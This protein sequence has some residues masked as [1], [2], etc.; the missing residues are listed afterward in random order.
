M[1]A[2]VGTGG[3][4]GYAGGFAVTTDFCPPFQEPV[5][6]ILLSA[7]AVLAAGLLPQ[8][9]LADDYTLHTFERIELTDTYF[10]EGAGVGDIN[11]DGH[12]DVV[13]GP[14]WFAGPDFKN[15]HEIYPAEP[16]NRKG[17]AN[18]FFSW[19][20]DF[21]GDGH[22]DVLA[23]GF[24]GTP[25]Y[26]YE[27]PGPDA[28][29]QLWE[30]HQV[31]DWVSNESPQLVNLVG[32]ET[33]ELVCTT[34]GKFGYVTVNKEEPFGT[35]EFTVIS[36]Q[37]VTERFGHGLG[38]GDVN[39]DGLMDILTKDGWFEQPQ[40]SGRRQPADSPEWTFH[41]VPFA[42]RGGA[43][44]FAYDVDGD[45]DND[46]ITSLAAHEFGLA[47]WEQLDDGEWK[48]HLI[49]GSKR[50]ENKYGVLF[51][52]LHAVALVDMDGDG[53]KDIVTGKT[54]W[55]HHEQSPMWDAGAVVYWFKLVRGEDGVD[56][57][58]FQI[59]GDT[60]IGRGLVVTDINGDGAPD[61]A[62]GG[63]KGANVLLQQR[64]QVSKAEWE[65]AQP[66]E[67]Q[68]LAAGLTPEEAVA[69][70]TVP[71]GFNVTLGAGEPQVHQPIAFAIDE[72]G[73]LWVAEAHTYPI[74]ADEGQGKDRI[75]ILED[76]NQDGTLDSSKT[77]IEGLNLVSGL[78][79]GFGGVWVGA[80]P[81]LMFIPD[82]DGN[83]VPDG[84]QASGRREPADVSGLTPTARQDVPPGATVLL[85]GF[86]YQDTHETLNAFN[87][88]PDGWLYGCHGVFTHSNVGRPGTPDDQR[89]PM[90]AAV[91]RYHPTRHEFE[92][93]A[94]GTSNPWGVDFNDHGDAFITACVIPHLY[95]VFP[96][97]RY[98]RQAGQHFNPYTY[99]DIQTI[100]RHRHYAGDIRDHAWWGQ[101]P[102]PPQST[103][104][105]GGGHAHAGAMVYLGDNW[106][107]AY[108]NQIFMHNIHGNR[109]NQDK[110]IPQGSGYAGDRAP[111]LMLANDQWFRGINLKYGP[112]GTVW[113][114][115]WYDKNACHRR[116][117][118]IWDR[119][120]GRIY[121]V[122]SGD[123]ERSPVD[124]RLMSDLQLAELQRH[125]NDWYVRMSRRLL[126][127]RA[128][129]GEIAQEA[130]EALR[131]M[132]YLSSSQVPR[133]LRALWTLHAIDAIPA[134]DW[135]RLLSDQSEQV[136]AWAIRLG[137]DRE[138]V[139]STLVAKLAALDDPSPVVRRSLAS[140]MPHLPVRAQWEIARNLITHGE[141][142]DDHNLPLL[143]WY[144][145]EP[146]VAAQ[147][148]EAL[149]LAAR[150]EI[151]LI[152]RFIVRR[153]AEESS[154]HD[155]LFAFLAADHH[156]ETR[157]EYLQQVLDGF[158]GRVG[159]AMPPA[160]KRAYE[161]LGGSDSEAVRDR[162]DQIAVLLGDKRVFPKLRSLLTDSEAPLA[163]RQAALQTLVRGQDDQAAEVLQQVV[164]VPELRGAAI[165]ALSAYDDPQTPQVLL[166]QYAKLPAAEQADAM[167]TLTAR[168]AYAKALLSAIE[169]GKVPRTD[170]H[171]YHVQQMLRFDDP[172]LKEQITSVWGAIRETSAD[173]QQQIAELKQKLRP[174]VL[175]DADHSAGRGVFAKTCAACHTLF[176]DGGKVGPDLTGSNRANLDYI[177]E[178]II[179][180][181]AVLGKDYRQSVIVTNDGRVI[182]GLVQKETDSAL[183]VRTIND[184]VVVPLADIEERAL[185]EVSMMPERLLDTLS[186]EEVRDLVAYL[187]SP[188]QVPLK[189]PRAPIDASTGKV[190]GAIEGES[191]Q[192]LSTSAG[193]ARRQPMANFSADRWSGNDQL[194]WTGGKPG[195]RLDLAVPVETAGTYEV[196]VV[197]TRAR[198]YGIVQLMLNDEPLGGPIDLFNAPD[199][200]T[201]GVLT[202][203]ARPLEAGQHTLGVEIVGTNPQ[204]AKAYMFAIDYL[205]LVPAAAP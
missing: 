102:V 31:F 157:E 195:D 76:T 153:A 105:A 167:S 110:L 129:E 168:P 11:G 190:E 23:V 179:D 120:N 122:S 57:L 137:T 72:R 119:T 6:R 38:V 175:A 8:S 33:P 191:L 203:P 178:N 123:V 22:N 116:S 145:I 164:L 10:S 40:A 19:V 189:G 42:P 155:A 131:R 196:E 41:K 106:P 107:D 25:C 154:A 173:K 20:Y 44:M 55:S 99:A 14:Y 83:D 29:D 198:D 47:W 187:G 66:K 48:Q 36:P 199:V 53:L 2:T 146:L 166:E 143:Y 59:N 144:G 152:S 136:R 176:G 45:G 132:A 67:Y 88:G 111:D 170:L 80:A 21:D 90:N 37:D 61:I 51:S 158:E 103:L 181:S 156:D 86:G 150:S 114:I 87:W 62:V 71:R 74:R 184:T 165:R 34:R 60:G 9:T 182:S 163:K 159:I 75:I 141:D 151:P 70:M 183:T 68:P 135:P 171:A 4:I 139:P 186:P 96:G 1:F 64:K 82:R 81:Y 94:E 100:A 101:E 192:V 63:M 12:M 26:V 93:F 95:H 201:T 130:V 3:W 117:P 128:A 148:E 18:S 91:W 13:H 27:N 113:L 162:A 108:R 69:Q 28:L 193:S 58:P 5:M 77:F 185:S 126:Q 17:Y 92:I 78:E 174:R 133:R 115:D 169:G 32:D 194:W 205:R 177:L 52:E 54:Y 204:A 89:T 160:W 172:A 30:K 118:E 73:R 197:L 46:V 127:H 98:Q 65:A 24:P 79:V 125:P 142:A 188:T 85:D 161:V 149:L 43:D 7:A 104:D 138:E 180:P 50:E 109:I 16:Q 84:L 200:I 49:M 147:P 124:L 112:D 202:F 134:G 35:W 56:W 39:G 140:A 15:K 121:N 97:G